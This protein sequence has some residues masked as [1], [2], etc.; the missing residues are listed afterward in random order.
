MLNI[1]RLDR[2]I[3]LDIVLKSALNRVAGRRDPCRQIN[4]PA[5]TPRTDIPS[6]SSAAPAKCAKLPQCRCK[7]RRK[8]FG[9]HQRKS[10]HITY[11]VSRVKA[12]YANLLALS[13]GHEKSNI[14]QS[15]HHCRQTKVTLRLNVAHRGDIT[16]K[17]TD[18]TPLTAQDLPSNP[19]TNTTQPLS[20][21]DC[22]IRVNTLRH[23]HC[24]TTGG[25]TVCIDENGH[26]HWHNADHAHVECHQ[27]VPTGCCT[28]KTAYCGIHQ[29]VH[30]PTSTGKPALRHRA[31]YLGCF[32]IS[33]MLNLTWNDVALQHDGDS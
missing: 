6:V 16:S 32:R 11:H 31:S 18:Y 5:A 33:Q 4:C 27:R 24:A 10:S 21:T 1:T 7:R 26:I 30:P 28:S 8:R 23:R 2:S 14:H 15:E 17:L 22:H 12:R 29:L 3:P 13:L 19:V 9:H 20:T 25:T